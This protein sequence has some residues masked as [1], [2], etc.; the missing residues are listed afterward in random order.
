MLRFTTVL[1]RSSQVDSLVRVLGEGLAG[2]SRAET[3]FS[4]AA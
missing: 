1:R 3:V 2:E 4:A